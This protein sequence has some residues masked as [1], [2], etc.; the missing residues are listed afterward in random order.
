MLKTKKKQIRKRK[1]KRF[2]QVSKE[3]LKFTKDTGKQLK[4]RYYTTPH[5]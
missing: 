4:K 5:P 2:P 1:Q 3:K